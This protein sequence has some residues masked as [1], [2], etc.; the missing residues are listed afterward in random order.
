MTRRLG[1]LIFPSFTFHA[2]G[3]LMSGLQLEHQCHEGRGQLAQR[4]ELKV[5]MCLKRLTVELR[6]SSSP[7]F[8][9]NI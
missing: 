1:T 3:Y 7:R 6:C 8:D 2:A 4:L 5:S 9:G